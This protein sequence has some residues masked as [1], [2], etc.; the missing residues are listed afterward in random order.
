MRNPE[1]CI[2]HTDFAAYDPEVVQYG[3]WTGGHTNIMEVW[4]YNGWQAETR[5]WKE[6][7]YLSTH[8]SGSTTDLCIKGPD[9]ERFMSENF[10]NNS[11][12]EK[13]PVGKGKHYIACSPKG[14]I[15]AHGVGMR[16]AEDC[17]SLAGFAMLAVAEA[18]KK[19][20]G[21]NI[22]IAGG[23]YYR[24]LILQVCG[25]NS[26]S[27]MQEAVDEDLHDLKFMYFRDAKVNG[28]P[29]R[30]LRMGM[31]GTLAYEI[32]AAAE[33]ALDVYNYVVELGKKYKA[34]RLGLLAYMCNHTLNG[35]PQWGQHFMLGSHDDPDIAPYY[36]YYDKIELH[37]S[38]SDLGQE[39]YYRNPIELG[40]GKMINWKHDFKGKEAL[41]KIKEDPRT[42]QI[43]NLEWNVDDIM[44]IHRA[45]YDREDMRLPDVMCYPQNYYFGA[46]GQLGDKV[47]DEN[48]KMIGKSSGVLYDGYYKAT[49]SQCVIDPEYNELGK[50]VTIL[51]GTA[52]TRQIPIRA[53]VARYPYL[54]LPAN[55]DYDIDSIPRYE[56]K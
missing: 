42:R 43:C 26:L 2:K 33:D 21:Y 41:L 17:F 37:G 49:I 23:K 55:R 30:V 53:K 1:N 7:V 19:A 31:G 12:L 48:G 22:E 40:W 9:A 47:L 38:M 18:A 10:V 34:E 46:D 4:E 6:S 35:F 54:D 16:V 28:I 51:W 32:H 14:T 52:G 25:P 24:G 5:S 36:E 29:V 15:I 13:F 11:T 56:K 44:K 27:L 45:M 8:L 39:A 50:E 3:R 20:K